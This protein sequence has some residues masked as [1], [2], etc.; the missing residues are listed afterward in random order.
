[1][2][3]KV[4]L[5]KP[6]SI[7]KARV[8]G[9]LGHRRYEDRYLASKAAY[10]IWLI[11]PHIVATPDEKLVLV[12]NS[13]AGC[14]SATSALYEYASG[15]SAPADIHRAETSL[16]GGANTTSKAIELLQNSEAIKFTFVRHPE[17]RIMSAFRNFVLLGNNSSAP[18]F[19]KHLRTF[20]WT[21]EETPE[22]QL[23]L[24]LD[25]VEN[26]FEKS[27]QNTDPHF[28]TQCLNT[29]FGT[30]AYS[31]IGRLEN[32]NDDLQEV[33]EMAGVWSSRLEPLLTFVKNSTKRA[34]QEITVPQRRRLETLYA[35]DFEAFGY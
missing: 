19:Q 24:F 15:K 21:S 9:A 17:A 12:K 32:Y 30:I 26:S 31:K 29:A 22:R 14:T 5:V 4:L 34:E 28:R 10:P 33:F 20:G 25:Y 3:R 23:D 16:L 1:M 7:I 27:K 2:K 11:S 35:E 8:F 13:K 18:K 6:K